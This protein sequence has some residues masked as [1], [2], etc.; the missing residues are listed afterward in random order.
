MT[1]KQHLDAEDAEVF[2]E[3]AKVKVRCEAPKPSHHKD[4]KVTK[5]KS[6]PKPS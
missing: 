6:A 1:K 5:K 3:V 2:A 4:T